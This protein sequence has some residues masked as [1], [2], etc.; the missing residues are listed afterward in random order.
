MSY[1][2]RPHRW[3]PTR[4][5]RPWDSPGKNTSVVSLCL[6]QG[7][8]LTTDQTMSPAMQAHS[9][10]SEPPGKPRYNVKCYGNSWDEWQIQVVFFG[11]SWIFFPKYFPCFDWI[12]GYADTKGRLYFL[13]SK[14][15]V[16]SSGNPLQWS[17][18]E[19][20]RDGGAWWAA[21]YGVA[22]SRT[23]LKLLSSSSSSRKIK[24]NNRAYFLSFFRD[25]VWLV[26]FR[27]IKERLFVI[28]KVQT[29]WIWVYFQ[30]HWM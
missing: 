23:R 7:I 26:T 24:P 21:V 4:L 10:L 17:C 13:L 30:V 19:N 5:P 8:F 29:A 12:H 2:V 27:K 25:D 3:Q 16:P 1:S 15:Q 9:L 22:Q 20:P 18:L 6:P 28:K 14:Y 11:I